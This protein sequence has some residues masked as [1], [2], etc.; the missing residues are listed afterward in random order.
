MIIIYLRYLKRNYKV[1]EKYLR[2]IFT[3]ICSSK[4][5]PGNFVIFRIKSS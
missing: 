1:I 5:G 3:L 4:N 2:R